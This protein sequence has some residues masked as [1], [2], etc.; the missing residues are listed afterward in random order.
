MT[1]SQSP[2]EGVGSIKGKRSEQAEQA[3]PGTVVGMIRGYT[4]KKRPREQAEQ[5]SDN[6]ISFPSTPGCQLVN[7]PIILEALI[8]GFL[9]RRIYVDGGSS[10]EVMYEHCFRNLRAETKAKLKESRTPLVGFYGEVS[11]PIGTINLNVTMGESKRL[12]TIPMEF[13]VVKS[14]SRY[15]VILGQT[16]LRSLGVIASTI[17]SMIKCPTAN[18]IAIVTT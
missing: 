6:E 1:E 10:S 13:T 15:N 17:H 12:R 18:R 16:S 8:E 4:S 2:E 3:R 7:S 9:V 5:W 11:Y 14:H